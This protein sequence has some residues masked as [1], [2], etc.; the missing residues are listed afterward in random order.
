MSLDS[1]LTYVDS[2]TRIF[3]RET[4]DE[5]LTIEDSDRW[6]YRST[7]PLQ[8]FTLMRNTATEHTLVHESFQ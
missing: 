7:N 1:S 3:P 2:V 8:L 4:G 5:L 6:E